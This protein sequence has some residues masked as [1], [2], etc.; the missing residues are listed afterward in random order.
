[1]AS[2]S[3]KSELNSSA[4]FSS[5]SDEVDDI[6]ITCCAP[7][8][9]T[10]PS[11]VNLHQSVK[12][13]SSSDQCVCSLF[14]H[15]ECFEQFEESVLQYLKLSG[16]A[17]SW[18]EKQRRQ[19][20]WS[21]RGY[22]LAFK[23]CL[24]KC[25]K[26][27]LKKD[28]DQVE[29][30]DHVPVT[31]SKKKKRKS[32]E[33]PLLILSTSPTNRNRTISGCSTGSEGGGISKL[34]SPKEA[35]FSFSRRSD[36]HAFLVA[37]PKQKLNPYHIKMED[38]TYGGNYDENRNFVLSNL[39]NHKVHTVHCLL[40]LRSLPVYDRYPLIDGTFFLSIHKSHKSAVEILHNGYNR[41]LCA[42]CVGCLHGYSAKVNCKFCKEEWQGDLFQLGTLYSFDIFAANPCC[43]RRTQCNTCNANVLKERVEASFSWFAQ[44]MQCPD[45]GTL[46][47]HLI[48][49]HLTVFK[50]TT[51]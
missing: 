47:Y 49:P 44:Q 36:Y 25:K 35:V 9:C 28:L 48:K 27:F 39:T 4:S 46:D 38:E 30:F 1:M 10:V 16:R 17:R 11:P 18:S 42:V 37:L 50:I 45:C 34:S 12:L 51:D 33:K 23:A 40:C 13:T 26:G 14:M 32:N 8:G 7:N 21:K 6:F 41:Y 29:E 31:K 15:S 22:D 19:N 43:P 20:I 3:E 24:C 5:N 2:S